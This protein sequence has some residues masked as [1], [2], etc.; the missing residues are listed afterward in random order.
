MATP[1]SPLAASSEPA[2]I[3][4]IMDAS[5][6]R[7]S[8]D[9]SSEDTTELQ[10]AP[11]PL[12]EPVEETTDVV[13]EPVA[14]ETPE[15]VVEEDEWDEGEIAPDKVTDNGR[16]LHFSKQ[17]ASRML[18]SH[19]FAQK[20]Q[21]V[22]PGATPE[23]LAK[24]W[25]HSVVMNEMLSDFDSGDPS[26]V[27]KVADFWFGSQS[28]PK[29][30]EVMAG[31]LMRQLPHTAPQL[32][33]QFQQQATQG[34]A[35]NLYEQAL[36][37]GDDTLFTLAQ[38]L[39]HRMSGKYL[40]KDDFQARD[41]YAEERTRFERERNEFNAM[42]QRTAQESIQQ[43]VQ[44]IDN[45]VKGF[46]AQEIEAGLDRVKE[47]FKDTPHMKHMVRDLTEKVDEAIA[48]N[49][50]WQRQFDLQK[51][52]AVQDTTGKAAADLKA[53]MK[54]FVGRVVAQHRKGVIESVSG[55]VL[56]ANQTAH[57]Q[58]AATAARREPAGSQ[59]PVQR[60]SHTQKLRSAKS[61]DEAWDIAF[62]R[63]K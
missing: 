52:R 12:D 38:N 63:L 55:V 18:A 29:S 51:Q 25:E 14:E 9:T 16:T 60:T 62:S 19:E 3:D 1:A 36:R 42:K 61:A 49:P 17:K 54:N 44:A 32:Y 33:Q 26:R 5:I 2:T 59:A 27:S 22:V 7:A 4:S 6:E 35:Q 21:S 46:K 34:L 58:A 11:E 47:Q 24:H 48:A 45:D 43:R 13:D 15:P 31:A 56:S 57:K 30:V 40:T 8:A 37:S 39:D 50:T 53:M 20:V 10:D 41:P 28:N 23:D